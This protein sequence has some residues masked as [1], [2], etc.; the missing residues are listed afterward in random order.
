MSRQKP[1]SDNPF[2]G[3]WDF[4]EFHRRVHK[5]KTDIELAAFIRELATDLVRG[6]SDHE[7]ANLVLAEA[8]GF[9]QQKKM[10]SRAGVAARRKLAAERA[11]Y[12][13]GGVT[14]EVTAGC[15]GDTTGGGVELIGGCTG[16]DTGEVTAGCTGDTKLTA[17]CTGG[18][19]QIAFNT[20]SPALRGKIWDVNA[21]LDIQLAKYREEVLSQGPPSEEEPENATTG[22]E[23][24][25]FTMEDI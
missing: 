16:D 6:E 19:T 7:Y 25:R 11:V 9:I 15:T 1:M 2:F 3:R 24:E 12:L 14:G 10:A 5:F 20:E 17:G 18:V 23:P 13:I 8:A 21:M 4:G 22:E